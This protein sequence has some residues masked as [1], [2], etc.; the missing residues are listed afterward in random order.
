ML[1]CP[2][3]TNKLAVI[4]GSGLRHVLF[5]VPISLIV[6]LDDIRPLSSHIKIASNPS[7]KKSRDAKNASHPLQRAHPL[8]RLL[9]DWYNSS[10]AYCRCHHHNMGFY[11]VLLGRCPL[12]CRFIV[13]VPA[14]AAVMFIGSLKVRLLVSIGFWAY[15][16]S[17]LK[18]E[19]LALHSCSILLLLQILFF[20]SPPGSTARS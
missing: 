18:L 10:N 7:N 16:I 14:T 12:S 17:S 2:P 13:R 6:I 11:R 3:P 15:A 5:C 8:N 19:P 20:K 9:H 4:L 1:P